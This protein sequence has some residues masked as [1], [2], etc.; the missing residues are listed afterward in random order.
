[1]G[2][3][4]YSHLESSRGTSGVGQDHLTRYAVRPV[5]E[6]EVRGARGLAHSFPSFQPSSLP[7]AIGRNARQH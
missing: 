6:R 7:L 1:M 3:H 4:Q 2:T 5:D